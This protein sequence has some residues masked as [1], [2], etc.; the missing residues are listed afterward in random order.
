MNNKK[1]TPSASFFGSQWYFFAAVIMTV[2]LYI[3]INPYIKGLGVSEDEAVTSTVTVFFLLGVFAG[4]YIAQIWFANSTSVSV[5]AI[6]GNITLLMACIAWLF[7]HADFP[8]KHKPAINLFLFWLPFAVFS[9]GLGILIKMI[10]VVGQNK[11]KEA[12]ANAE[13]SKSEL[14]LLQ[15]QL[16]PHFLFNTLNNMYGLSITQHEKLPALLLKLSELLRYSVYEAGA[17]YVPLKDELAYI[18]NYIEFEKIRVGERL[19][20]TLDIENAGPDI[21]IAPMLLIVFIENAFKHAK[22]TA[23]EKIYI[24][25]A[26]KTWGN[27]VLFSV[28]NSHCKI[29]DEASLIDKSNGLGLANVQKRLALLY[30]NKYDLAVQDEE[31]FYNVMLQLKTT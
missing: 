17:E 8:L 23:D 30:K 20:L 14:Y 5:F 21:M 9:I 1:N 12:Q 7:I 18:N 29:K 6:A 16:S 11:L 28:K 27:S 13:Q 3:A 26:L 10:R 31:T 15:S 4:R 22:N 2:P 24:D 19:V 25:I